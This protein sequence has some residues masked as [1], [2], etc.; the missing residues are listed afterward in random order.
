MNLQE[1]TNRIKQMMGVINE[2]LERNIKVRIKDILPINSDGQSLQ[3]AITNVK[4]GLVSHSKHN[5]LLYRVGKKYEVGD[6]FHRIA[7]KILN[8]EKYIIADIK[9]K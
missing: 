3:D 9:T 1:Q 2:S 4:D 6:G 7:Q 5:V 8:G